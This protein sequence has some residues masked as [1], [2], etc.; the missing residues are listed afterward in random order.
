MEKDKAVPF[1]A[2]EKS[3][4]ADLYAKQS[5]ILQGKF[6]GPNGSGLRKRKWAEIT[7]AVNAVGG[8]NRTIAQVKKKILNVK[9][10]VKEKAASN[11]LSFRKTGGGS[12]ED[13][14]LSSVEDKILSTISTRQIR[15]I[16]GGIDTNELDIKATNS[17]IPIKNERM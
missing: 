6:E 15:G 3:V 9:G 2:E 13:E 16:P 12:D 8:N 11:K 1:T 4:L 14:E 5:S 7:E 10:I 17:S